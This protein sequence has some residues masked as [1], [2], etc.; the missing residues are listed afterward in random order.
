MNVDKNQVV[1]AVFVTLS[2]I[3]IY[4]KNHVLVVIEISK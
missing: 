1:L 4:F 2:P 3:A